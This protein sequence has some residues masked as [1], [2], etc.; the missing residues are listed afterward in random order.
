[1]A[2]RKVAAMLSETDF[3]DPDSVA[4][5]VAN[6]LLALKS[7]E[8]DAKTE[9]V[10]VNAI[11]KGGNAAIDVYNFVS[12]LGYL[13]PAFE[14]LFEG[15][16]I[17]VLSPGQRGMVLLLFYLLVDPDNIPLVVDQPEEN[18]DNHTVV[19]YLTQA[20]RRAR[21]RRQ[22]VV[23]THNAN[24]AVVCDADQIIRCSRGSAEEFL[25]DSAPL[26]SVEAIDPVVQILEGTRAAFEQRG[27]KYW[28]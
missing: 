28:R 9:L 25:Y 11:V 19:S 14:L 1:M 10:D 7:V 4:E 20:F 22:L 13:R 23:V 6:I 12:G 16:S 15:K 26:E 18:L 21:S 24:L 3:N 8:R 2:D 17:A 5:F 27:H